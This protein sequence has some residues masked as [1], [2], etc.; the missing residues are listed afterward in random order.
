MP[1]KGATTFGHIHGSLAI[2]GNTLSEAQITA[3]LDGKPVIA[4]PREIQ[5]VRNALQAYELLSGWEPTQVADLL[6]AHGC[7]M[8]GLVDDAGAW[9]G[10]GVGVMA[11]DRVIHMAT[12]AGRVPQLMANLLRWLA[13]TDAHP[14]IASSIFH[15]E[16]EFI[17][18]FSDGNGRMGRL[19]QT[20]SLRHWNPLFA[21]IPV[22]SLV[23][24]Q[25]AAYCQAIQ[26]STQQSDAAP[27]VEF[28]LNRILDAVTSVSPQ[29]APQVTPQVERLLRA[30]RGEMSRDALQ[31]EL[32]LQDRKSFRERYLNPALAA[33]LIEMSLPHKPNS[34]LQRY[35]LTDEGRQL[36]QSTSRP[37][38][39]SSPTRASRP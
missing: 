28:M 25:Q 6:A 12:Q 31:I 3:I 37:P 22:E 15:Y 11:G 10:K 5:E 21:E 27:F 9:R 29:V 39:T 17:H 4:L 32:A 1:A 8:R 34:R 16:F 24:E 18:P 20:L 23:H 7:L 13:A 36:L 30:M 14:L 35:R 19:W 33:G 38:I 26:A 2:E